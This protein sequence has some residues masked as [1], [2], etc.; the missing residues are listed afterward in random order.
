MQPTSDITE[1]RELPFFFFFLYFVFF[2]C[3]SL[4]IS[5]APYRRPETARCLELPQQYKLELP[6]QDEL[7]DIRN[8]SD[9]ARDA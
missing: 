1:P 7:P 8:S 2:F 6:T 9:T 5:A 3:L 4:F